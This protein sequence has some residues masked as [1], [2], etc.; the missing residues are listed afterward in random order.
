VQ[1]ALDA[2]PEEI[3][4][5]IMVAGTPEDWVRW[6]REIYAAAVSPARSSRSRIHLA[7]LVRGREL[8]GYPVWR[9]KFGW[10]VNR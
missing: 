5:R 3:A 4:D 2:A 7:G 6:L 10:W 8:E 1:R 9:N